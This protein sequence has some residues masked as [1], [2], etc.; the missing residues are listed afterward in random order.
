MRRFNGTFRV[1]KFEK[2]SFFITL[3]GFTPH[4]EHK[5]LDAI[6]ADS[7]GVYSS[8]KIINLSMINETYL[9]CDG[10]DGSVVNGLRQ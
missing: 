7:P 2:K 8:R 3:L 9:K 1:L 6:Q 4:W 5:P 10:I